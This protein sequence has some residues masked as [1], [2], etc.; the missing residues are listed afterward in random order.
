MRKDGDVTRRGKGMVR[1]KSKSSITERVA[2]GD[3]D[4]VKGCEGKKEIRQTLSG[5]RLMAVGQ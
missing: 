1:E 4:R 2:K 5:V 3:G